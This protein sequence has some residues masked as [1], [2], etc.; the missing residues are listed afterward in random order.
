MGIIVRAHS[1]SDGAVARPDQVNENETTLYNLVNGNIDWDNI[2]AALQNAANGLVKLDEDAKVLL[3]Q[4]PA[5]I[6]A[7]KVDGLHASEILPSGVIVMWSGTLATIPAG[8]SLCNGAGGTPDLRDKFI[9]GWSNG[10]DP[11]GTGG[12][13]SH[14][15]SASSSSVGYHRHHIP[16]LVDASGNLLGF[17]CEGVD[18]RSY[19][20]W[21]QSYAPKNSCTPWTGQSWRTDTE[22]EEAH[23]HTITVASVTNVPPY[24]KLAFIIKD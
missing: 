9:Y 13:T 15:H 24:Y 3:A 7:D 10:V 23:T 6:D 22:A 18:K 8:W 11:G 21:N 5:G 20:G 2:K 16:I 4:I 14:L 12:S 17:D 1:F 19:E